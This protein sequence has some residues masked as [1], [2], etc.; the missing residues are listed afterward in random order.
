MIEVT[1]KFYVFFRTFC[2]MC[3]YEL[4]NL[5]DRFFFFKSLSDVEC[6]LLIL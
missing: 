4:Q 1:L 3:V 2:V 5:E 6:N